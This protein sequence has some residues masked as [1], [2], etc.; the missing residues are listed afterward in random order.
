MLQTFPSKE[1]IRAPEMPITMK[2]CNTA[3]YNDC[4]KKRGM[5][6]HLFDEACRAWL[7][8]DRPKFT[9][10]DRLIEISAILRYLFNY[11]YRQLEGLLEDYIANRNLNFPIPD[12]ST[13]CRRVNKLSINISDHRGSKESSADEALDVVLDSTGINIYNTGGGHAKE[14]GRNRKYRHL[15]QFRKLHVAINP[16]SKKAICINMT[17]GRCADANV[18]PILLASITE[19]IGKVYADGAY[20]RVLV[21]QACYE[22]GAR[23]IIPP[24][25]K[26][27]IRNKKNSN[28]LWED[29]NTAVR[30]MQE[31]AYREEGRKKWKKDY[32]YGVRSLIEAFF[33]RF[34]A[35]FGFH[36]MSR[37]E[38]SRQKELILKIKI[39]NS[40]IDLGGAV[41][42]KVV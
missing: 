4:L 16:K 10:T 2:V 24:N 5:I 13:L 31:H 21:R 23:Q 36:F 15:D 25:I 28:G 26:A 12:Y 37:K 6:F 18:A 8:R 38:A 19:P 22:R 3:D 17:P 29:R 1:L 7:D 41:F 11:R 35:I 32:S 27:I 30:Y 39:L 34:K 20:D 40:F 33:G 9:Y 14:N 42:K